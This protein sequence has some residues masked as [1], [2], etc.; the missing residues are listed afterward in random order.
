LIYKKSWKEHVQHVDMVFKTLEE[1]QLYAK[2]SNCAFGARKVEYLGHIISHEG[3]KVDPNKIKSMIK[4]IILK[5]LKN[6]RGFLQ[7]THYYD[8]FVKNYDPMATP[9]TKL[10]KKM[11]F[12]TQE[13]T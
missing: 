13:A 2:P 12:F 6:L 7:F 10:L 8:K 3:V 4:W 9:L 5:T 1:Q 11:F